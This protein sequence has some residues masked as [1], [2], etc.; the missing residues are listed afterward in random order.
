[1]ESLPF[2]NP[3]TQITVILVTVRDE[4]LEQPQVEGWLGWFSQSIYF[5]PQ[6]SLLLNFFDILSEKMSRAL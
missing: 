5:S 4:V 2:P 1:M 6:S 3:A